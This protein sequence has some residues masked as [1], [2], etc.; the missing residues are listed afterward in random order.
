MLLLGVVIIGF[1]GTQSLPSQWFNSGKRYFGFPGIN[2]PS[3]SSGSAGY[4]LS[5]IAVVLNQTLS[6]LSSSEFQNV[7][8]AISSFSFLNYPSGLTSLMQS[9][10]SEIAS[11]NSS[12]PI[13]I[14]N[15]TQAHS[16]ADHGLLS[17]RSSFESGCVAIS[18][19]NATF[20]RFQNTLTPQLASQGMPISLYSPALEALKSEVLS[21]YNECTTLIKVLGLTIHGVNFSI[22]SPVQSFEIGGNLPVSGSININGSVVSGESILFFLNG[23]VVGRATSGQDGNFSA[24][25]QMPFVYGSVGALWAGANLTSTTDFLI[26]SNTLYFQELYNQTAIILNT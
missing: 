22:Y 19:V 6:L 21:L 8:L 18:Q 25:L 26:V 2:L 9:A 11:M 24:S 4:N 13:A 3:G 12:L 15:L 10:Q 23:T 14:S 5:G 7:S 16:L 1:F 20:T 17:D